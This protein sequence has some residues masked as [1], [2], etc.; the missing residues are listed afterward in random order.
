MREV[1]SSRDD[2]RG[3]L[4]Q[5]NLLLKGEARDVVIA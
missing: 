3:Q 1:V 5:R 4:F 2:Q